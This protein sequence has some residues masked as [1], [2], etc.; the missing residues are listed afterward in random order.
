MTNRKTL[1]PPPRLSHPEAAALNRK[2]R[3]FKARSAILD[4]SFAA[5]P[6]LN[7]T[8]TRMALLDV[9]PRIEPGR[10]GEDCALAMR[11]CVRIGLGALDRG[12]LVLNLAQPGEIGF[13]FLLGQGALGRPEFAM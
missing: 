7:V 8:P 4:A 9:P 11:R 12:Q 10:L 6:D 13:R 1:K 3:F 2:L 5:I